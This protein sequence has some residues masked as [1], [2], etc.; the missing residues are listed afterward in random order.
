MASAKHAQVLKFRES[1][2]DHGIALSI[3]QAAHSANFP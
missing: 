3:D 1:N 2:T